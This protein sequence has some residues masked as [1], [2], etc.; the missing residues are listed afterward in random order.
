MIRLNVE[1][2]ERNMG[3]NMSQLRDGIKTLELQL[4]EEEQTGAK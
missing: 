3:N 1:K 2:Y 4:S